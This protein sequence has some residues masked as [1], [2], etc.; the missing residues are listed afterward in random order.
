METLLFDRTMLLLG[1]RYVNYREMLSCDAN[2]AALTHDPNSVLSLLIVDVSEG[3]SYYQTFFAGVLSVILLEYLHFRSQPHDPDDHAMR[4][5]A[6]AGVAVTLLMYVYSVALLV[7]GVSYKMLL[8]EHVYENSGKRRFLSPIVERLL[9]GG[10]SAALR[11]D[12]DD[13]RQR[14]AHFFGA[15]LAIVFVC[16]DGMSLA[17]KGIT[18]SLNRCQCKET[19][20]VRLSVIIMVVFRVALVV[21]FATLSQYCTDPSLLA[22]LGF[23]GIVCQLLI[24]VL[25]AFM[26]PPDEDEQEDQALDRVAQYLNARIGH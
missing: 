14:I 10:E 16:L 12:T 15:S 18:A 25:G 19:H 5:K 4:R 24:R 13:R 17:H 8:Q 1:E 20:V 22:T 21:F 2:S 11:F 6:E 23:V 26:F 3:F 7:I 9:A